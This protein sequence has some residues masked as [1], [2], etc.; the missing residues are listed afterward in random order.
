VH[1][2]E[3]LDER[4]LINRLPK[5]VAH[6]PS[7]LPPYNTSDLDM[8]M[9]MLRLAALEERLASLASQCVSSCSV[10][11]LKDRD[12]EKESIGAEAYTGRWA[13]FASDLQD[14]EF[15]LVS[16]RRSKPSKYMN[17]VPP[18]TAALSKPSGSPGP[19]TLVHHHMLQE[20]EQKKSVSTR[21]C[22]LRGTR[23]SDGN[24]GVSGVPRRLTAFVGRLHSDTTEKDLCD[25]LSN[26]G[27][28]EVKCKK[29]V[30]KD[31]RVFRT[32]AFM[33]SCSA[34]SRDLFYNESSWP[35]GAELRDWVFY[36]KKS[37]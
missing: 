24:T 4:A 19:S 7:R 17:F 6:D 26:L 15:T 16:R 1:L 32:A 14:G 25:V 33:V 10:G 20:Q 30:A 37:E 34:Q 5:F 35:E 9:L 8:C 28:K 31:G 18:N 11:D 27:I 23:G 2:L 36:D 29:L 3:V 12:A 22:V 13:E 21:R